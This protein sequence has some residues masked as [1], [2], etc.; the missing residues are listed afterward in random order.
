VA[1]DKPKPAT[2]TQAMAYRYGIVSGMLL[3]GLTL[4]ALA[5]FR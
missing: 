5:V 2:T 1:D 3:V 4:I